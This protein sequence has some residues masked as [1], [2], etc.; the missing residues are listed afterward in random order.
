MGLLV[1][2]IKKKEEAGKKEEGVEVQHA[3]CS[4]LT[5]LTR[6]TTSWRDTF[7]YTHPLKTGKDGVEYS[8]SAQYM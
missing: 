1:A 6:N 8:P 2:K 7:V 4:M 3:P 5:D